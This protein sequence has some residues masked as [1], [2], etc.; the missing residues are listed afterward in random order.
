MRL[1]IPRHRHLLAEILPTLRATRVRYRAGQRVLLGEFVHALGPRA[2]LLASMILA[3]P[4][5][6]PVGM[7]PIA[8]PV[9]AVICL[10]GV[11]I[12]RRQRHADLPKRWGMVELPR[13][14][15][16]MLRRV[17]LTLARFRHQER[18]IGRQRW[19]PKSSR[20][21]IVG[22]GIAGA[23]LLI[24]A[25]IPALPLTSTLLATG[26]ILM[27]FGALKRHDGVV[28]AGLV[29]AVLGAIWMLSVVI[30]VLVHG[31]AALG[32]LRRGLFGF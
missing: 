10:L 2:P 20:E 29:S 21:E 5:L 28:L 30:F 14:A 12:Y 19:I 9:G 18:R 6:S 22:G 27:A 8:I 3:I 32:E 25:P 24:A 23:A 16:D 4:F 13:R 1:P 31:W 11:G 15:F 7:A 26:I 17:L